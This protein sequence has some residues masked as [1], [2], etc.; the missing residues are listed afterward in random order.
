M[1]QTSCPRY[2]RGFPCPN[3]CYCAHFTNYRDRIDSSTMCKLIP[4]ELSGLQDPVRKKKKKKGYHWDLGDPCLMAKKPGCPCAKQSRDPTHNNCRHNNNSN[5]LTLPQLYHH[6]QT[7][8]ITT[9]TPHH[10][11]ITTTFT[12][13]ASFSL[14]RSWWTRMKRSQTQH[15]NGPHTGHWFPKTT[16]EPQKFLQPVT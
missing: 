4:R 1:R 14:E 15:G 9:T 12:I 7:T 11:H 16:R 5:N 10:H 8:S 13:K 6:L 3:R 2:Q